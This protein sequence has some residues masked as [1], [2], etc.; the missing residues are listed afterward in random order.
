MLFE[1]P[2]ACSRTLGCAGDEATQSRVSKR[3]PMFGT[4]FPLG[5]RGWSSL[6]RVVLRSSSTGPLWL[7]LD[8]DES[9]ERHALGA[10]EQCSGHCAPLHKQRSN[11]DHAG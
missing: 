2:T 1:W 4:T 9:A 6:H 8:G 7:E 11:T 5:V 10:A 3:L